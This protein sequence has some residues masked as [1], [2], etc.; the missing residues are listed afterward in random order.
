MNKIKIFTILI[1]LLSA[2]ATFSQEVI[3][4]EEAVLKTLSKN[5]SIQMTKNMAKAAD[6]AA[7]IGNAGF[8]PTVEATGGYDFT[9]NNTN[10]E[11]AGGI[12]PVDRE[13][14]QSTNLR[15]GVV[16]SYTIFNGL[17]TIYNYDRLKTQKNLADIETKITAEATVIQ[18]V[19]TYLDLINLKEIVK[20][21]E[22]NLALSKDRLRLAEENFKYGVSNRVDFLNAEVDFNNDSILLIES[23]L[24]Y[25]IALRELSYLMGDE[26]IRDNFE[27][28]SE[29]S[30]NDEV[31]FADKR[32]AALNNNVQILES[33]MSISLADTDLKAAR[34][35]YMPR[36]ATQVGYNY[37]E[38]Q[39]DVGILLSNKN[40]GINAGLTLQWNL[41]DGGKKNIMLKNAKLQLDNNQLMLQD[42][43]R[44]IDKDF[45]NAYSFY[46]KNIA[47]LKVEEKNIKSAELNFERSNELYKL[48][49]I[50]STQLREAQLNLLKSKSGLINAMVEAKKAEYEILRVA[51]DLLK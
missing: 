14:A 10:L 28:V 50:N 43:K 42:A 38:Q 49:K 44:F 25:E 15:A 51:G 31:N 23:Q 40:R 24:N 34:S 2:K 30:L 36:L 12:P 21:N 37:N 48:G 3:S 39:S 4:L 1:I 16:A 6:N 26:T 22:E 9:R 47:K 17:A 19:N 29:I 46:L 35:P 45:S 13:G 7:T 33:L 18:V 8:L 5:Y 32:Q 11:F 27:I 41:F 20:I